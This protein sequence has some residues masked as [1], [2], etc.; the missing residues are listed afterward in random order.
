MFGES[1]LSQTA[2]PFSIT[3]IHGFVSLSINTQ[4]KLTSEISCFTTPG[5]RC[6]AH[7][8]CQNLSWL[9]RKIALTQQDNSF[10]ISTRY[11]FYTVIIMA[12]LQCK[13]EW[14]SANYQ[15]RS[16]QN[17]SY[18]DSTIH[19]SMSGKTFMKALW[20]LSASCIKSGT[21]CVIGKLPM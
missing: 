8:T 21:N 14:K 9:S 17:I 6:N 15:T 19:I 10:H 12:N 20:T 16:K 1:G 4:V 7:N 13:L 3:Y 5:C 18:Q 11:A 2:I